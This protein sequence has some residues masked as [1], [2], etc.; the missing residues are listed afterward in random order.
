MLTSSP[1]RRYVRAYGVR[2]VHVPVS[3]TEETRDHMTLHLFPPPLLTA[4][5]RVRVLVRTRYEISA[6]RG[7]REGVLG[8]GGGFVSSTELIACPLADKSP[9]TAHGEPQ[10]EKHFLSDGEAGKQEPEREREGRVHLDHTVPIQ[11]D[12]IL[13][14]A[15]LRRNPTVPVR[16]PSSTRSKQWRD[17]GMMFGKMFH[18]SIVDSRKHSTEAKQKP[19]NPPPLPPPGLAYITVMAQ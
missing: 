14:V 12:Q 6:P 17:G 16:S 5:R 4:L 1:V 11:M 3:T 2:Y 8:S 13:R 19:H 9:T 10:R 15:S 18:L 7:T